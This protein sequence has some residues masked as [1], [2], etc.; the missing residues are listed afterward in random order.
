MP[1]TSWRV[2]PCTAPG[3]HKA[4]DRSDHG[5][6]DHVDQAL[7]AGVAHG[8]D[9][10]GQTEQTQTAHGVAAGAMKPIKPPPMAP[11]MQE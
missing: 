3:E 11:P 7:D 8:I 4:D 5:T 1:I 9:V 6:D 2:R 10:A